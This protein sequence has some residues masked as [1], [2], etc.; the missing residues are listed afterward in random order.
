MG[1]GPD[2]EADVKRVILLCAGLSERFGGF[3]KWLLPCPTAEG[4]LTLG[5][6]AAHSLDQAGW[7]L[8]IALRSSPCDLDRAMARRLRAAII[9]VGETGSPVETVR[10]AVLATGGVRGPVV[11]RDCDS[12]LGRKAVRCDLPLGFDCGLALVDDKTCPQVGDGGKSWAV[13]GRDGITVASLSE[14]FKPEGANL[15]S[16][17]AYLFSD[18][19][20]FMSA[21]ADERSIAEAMNKL[22]LGGGR[23]YG[24]VVGRF[25][26]YGTA[27]DWASR[28]GD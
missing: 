19:G 12:Y 8:A 18:V 2:L 11:V 17:G 5:E 1:D 26:D 9:V 16:V 3:R 23:C 25:D 24:Q 6:A 22:I 13:M 7:G 14:K 20:Q 15:F 27:T 21:S 4:C 10:R 28:I